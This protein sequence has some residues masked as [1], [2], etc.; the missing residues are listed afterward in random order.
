[1]KNRL[2]GSLIANQIR[3][4]LCSS[5]VTI[6]NDFAKL[7]G[8]PFIVEKLCEFCNKT[9]DEGAKSGCNTCLLK[10]VMDD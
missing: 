6:T 1:M 9:I 7:V 4:E 10:Y 2:L 3:S 8:T 5:S